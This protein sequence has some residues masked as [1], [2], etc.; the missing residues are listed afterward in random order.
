MK[1]V[2]Q[3]ASSPRSLVS[4]A[5]WMLLTIAFLWL[6]GCHL[7]LKATQGKKTTKPGEFSCGEACPPA[8][9]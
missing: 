7:P 9:P 5:K 1:S 3:S 8:I 6:V 4:S 2:S